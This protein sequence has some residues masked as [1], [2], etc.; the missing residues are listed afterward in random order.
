[1]SIIIYNNISW[2]ATVIRANFPTTGDRGCN[3]YSKMTVSTFVLKAK[4]WHTLQSTWWHW[5][6]TFQ[7]TSSMDKRHFHT[8]Q[9]HTIGVLLNKQRAL[10]D[11]SAICNG[12]YHTVY[13]SPIHSALHQDIQGLITF[14]INIKGCLQQRLLTWKLIWLSN[15]DISHCLASTVF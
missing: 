8:S 9:T 10:S 7:S 11:Y 12:V 14:G 5:T 4:L 2:I 3:K 6:V 1:M 13:I 15:R